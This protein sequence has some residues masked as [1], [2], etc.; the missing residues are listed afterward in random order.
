MDTDSVFSH[1]LRLVAVT[2][3]AG[4]AV[5]LLHRLGAAPWFEIGWHDL[6]L[7]LAATPVEDVLVALVRQVALVAA[8]W[9]LGGTILYT[10]ARLSRLP[11]M[12]RAVEWCALPAVRRMA[13]RAVAVTIV[14][15]VL[16]GGPAWA[17]AQ[18]PASGPTRYGGVSETGLATPGFL[19]VAPRPIQ[20]AALVS[21]AP[22]RPPVPGPAQTQTGADA[23]G[24]SHK[25]RPGESLWTIAEDTLRRARG[26]RPTNDETVAYWTALT[27]ENA[28]SL[29][30]GDPDLVYPDEVITLPRV[31]PQRARGSAG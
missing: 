4:L 17:G 31:P 14:G 24:S 18:S 15:S 2:A 7:W 21:S 29:R 8:Y 19:P 28:S 16:A 5:V 20:D 22:P 25:V 3:F 12:L 6:P 10:A 23:G 27:R 1:R 9:L 26:H 11:Q 13:D 30:S